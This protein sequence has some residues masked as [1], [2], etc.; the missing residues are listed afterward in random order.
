MI[1]PPFSPQEI[2]EVDH[3]RRAYSDDDNLSKA[4]L[5]FET[6]GWRQDN[7]SEEYKKGMYYKRILIIKKLLQK[8]YYYNIK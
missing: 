2:I 7:Y 3:F 1:F 5:F 4:A 6:N 8:S